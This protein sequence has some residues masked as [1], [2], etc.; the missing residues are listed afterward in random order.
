MVLRQVLVSNG[1][2]SQSQSEEDH[3]DRDRHRNHHRDHHRNHQRNHHGDHQ[4][5]HHRSDHRSDHRDRQ[6]KDYPK[7]LDL[8]NTSNSSTDT[9]DSLG[10]ASPP[11]IR[12]PMQAMLPPM[13]FPTLGSMLP[14]SLPPPMSMEQPPPFI[15][16]NPKRNG[17]NVNGRNVNVQSKSAT[18]SQMNQQTNRQTNNRKESN[19]GMHVQNEKSSKRD[20]QAMQAPDMPFECGFC[21]AK[22]MTKSEYQSH[23]DSHLWEK[24]SQCQFCFKSTYTCICNGS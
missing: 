10:V 6:S 13:T 17:T 11:M 2:D 14:S 5:D 19:Q 16:T 20:L 7:D 21:S 3:S 4:R 22:F 12:N 23:W 1:N 24:P 18:N 15:I 8:G 9:V